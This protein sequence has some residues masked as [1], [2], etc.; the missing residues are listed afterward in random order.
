MTKNLVREKQTHKYIY[1]ST[2]A[3]QCPWCGR[4]ALKDAAC[5]YVVC[6]RS[7]RGFVLNEGCAKAW[8]FECGGKLCG[9]PMYDLVTGR[10]LHANE[11]HNHRLGSAEAIEC[12]GE[13]YCPGGH[14]SHKGA[15]AA[16]AAAA[17][18]ASVR[19]RRF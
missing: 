4:W 11:N 13:G 19:G 17:I 3:K 5:N 18:T 8:C 16:I 10:Q 1:M 12:G 2:D 6:G 7:T 15:A 14:N 9:P